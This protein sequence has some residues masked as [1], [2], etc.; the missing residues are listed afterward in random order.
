MQGWTGS[1]AAVALVACSSGASDR[2]SNLT[3]DG[4]SPA[5]SEA[6]FDAGASD[7]GLVVAVGSD[8]SSI[9]TGAPV[10]DAAAP[11][12]RGATLPYVEYEAETAAT[13]GTLIGPSRAVNDTDVFASIAGESSGRQAVKLAG[14]GQYVRFTTRSVANSV[15]VRFAIPD[16]QDGTGLQATLGLYVNGTRATS[17]GLTSKFAWAY[18][19]PQTTDATTNNPGDGF[20]RHFYDEARVL[21]LMDIPAGTTIAL[22]EDA[23]DTAAYYVVDL[24][25]LEEVPAALPQPEGSLSVASYGVKGDGTTD[26][27]Q[28]IQNA[29]ND[30][31]GRGMNV[32]LPS[33]TYLDASTVLNL[34]SVTVYGA[35]MW[36]S[37]IEG[38]SGRFVC[39]GTACG[40]SDLALLGET[41]LRDDGASI[42]G[43]SGMFGTGSQIENVWIEHFTTGVWIGTNGNAPTSGL[44][45]HGARV[46]DTF[47]DGIN[48]CNGT[49]NST[50]EQSSARNTGDDAFASWAYAA[51]G[52]PPDTNNVFRFDTVQLPWRANCFA[53]YG[54]TGN[55]IE[56]DVCADSITYPG[57]LVDQEFNSHPFSGT[58]TVARSTIVRSGG[59]MYGA[60]WGAMTVSG[61]DTGS[62]I[63]GVSIS[64]VDIENPTYAGLFFTGPN[65]T[66]D[67]VTLAN[68][69]IGG[70]STYGIEVASTASGSATAT[71]VIVTTPGEGGLDNAAPTAWT[72]TRGAGNTGW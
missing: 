19:D 18:G 55:S 64:D 50:I 6:V 33:G 20:A 5:A 21:L 38:A 4:A 48:F 36:R 17:L 13:N 11:A 27:G 65:D 59:L 10:G 7:G 34:K 46:R 53:I 9:E 37:T 45:V 15:V 32:W 29:I 60:E 54:G 2:G 61:H 24:I 49:S 56:D 47:A 43:I 26:D 41:T 63:A 42:P 51:A 57:V 3:V 31:Q 62:A 58:T 16:S 22:Q 52:D 70:A 71:N 69:T 8:E 12:T 39:G 14:T 72:F 1:F 23:S 30:A 40:F 66:I 67:G 44:L 68:I 25:D 35:G 28:A